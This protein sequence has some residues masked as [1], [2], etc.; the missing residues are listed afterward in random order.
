M[1]DDPRVD[2]HWRADVLD[3]W[4][5]KGHTDMVRLLLR[6]RYTKA[7]LNDL[8]RAVISAA[9]GGYVDCVR[10]LMAAAVNVGGRRYYDAVKVWGRGRDALVAA[11]KGEHIETLKILFEARAE[12][13]D[14]HCHRT[15][16]VLA[17]RGGHVETVKLLLEAGAGVF[18]DSDLLEALREAVTASKEGHVGTLRL[19]LEAGAEALREDLHNVGINWGTGSDAVLA[20]SA[21]RHVETVKLLLEVG[22]RV[23]GQVILRGYLYMVLELAC[24]EGHIGIV[25]LLLDWGVATTDERRAALR[26]AAGSGHGDIVKEFLDRDKKIWKD[27]ALIFAARAG[28]VH[29]VRLL[30]EAGA[31]GS[32][33]DGYATDPDTIRIL[34]DYRKYARR[35]EIIREI[36]QRVVISVFCWG[37]S[38]ALTAP[39]EAFIADYERK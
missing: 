6:A 35:R 23:F 30:L 15:A 8:E 31:D 18:D 21:G 34:Q 11:S 3:D 26:K 25:K 19:L 37:V 28:H 27:G 39:L 2:A 24:G 20:A 5:G 12:A 33:C 7:E 4:A 29:V 14:A 10:M 38:V 36:I 9:E 16:L 13:L 32:C 22:A 17:S 1:L